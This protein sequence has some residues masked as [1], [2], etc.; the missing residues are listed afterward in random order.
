MRH[1]PLGFPREAPAHFRVFVTFLETGTLSHPNLRSMTASSH[2]F[3]FLSELYAFAGSFDAHAFRNAVLDAVLLRI[4]SAPRDLPYENVQDVYE[5]T[6]SSSSL[7]DLVIDVV[8]HIGR[9]RD[10]SRKEDVLP[11]SF[12]VDCLKMADED[13]IVPFQMTREWLE[14]KAERMCTEYHVHGREELRAAAM[15]EDDEMDED[16]EENGGHGMEELGTTGHDEEEVMEEDGDELEVSEEVR[17]QMQNIEDLR[18]L[19]IHY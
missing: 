12:L 6:T 9:S 5:H 13:G 7:R 4:M 18:K 17:Q 1:L 10:L 11:K 15:S 8:L 16:E 19:R 3:R 14:G 2:V